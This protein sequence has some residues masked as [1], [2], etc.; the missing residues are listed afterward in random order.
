MNEGR[1]RDIVIHIS[2]LC[3]SWG[4]PI[5]RCWLYQ[6]QDAHASQGYHHSTKPDWLN[7][8][9]GGVRKGKRFIESTVFRGDRRTKNIMYKG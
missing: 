6:L 2:S 4:V 1:E 5:G 8:D 3:L 9:Q 7:K